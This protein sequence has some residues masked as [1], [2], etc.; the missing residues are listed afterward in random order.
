[1]TAYI[2][3]SGFMRSDEVRGALAVFPD[4]GRSLMVG[5][6]VSAKTLSGQRNKYPNRYPLVEDIAN[7]FTDD[8]RCLN[9]IHYAS[10]ERPTNAALEHLL[11]IGGPHC[12]GFQFNGE[13]PHRAGLV[14]LLLRAGPGLRVVLQVRDFDIPN[15]PYYG[16]LVTDVLIDA[17]GG[18]GL[19][20]NVTAARDGV[21]RF[22]NW[23]GLGCGVAGGLCAETVGALAPLMAECPGLSID[24]E[25]RLRTE[26][27]DLDMA[28]VRAYLRAS[29]DAIEAAASAR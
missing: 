17:S 20:L 10:D 28:K 5:V 27:D 15:K 25:G 3:V 12:H 19:P 13:W 6:L 18:R 11:R 29:A 1:M 8:P 16:G 26:E 23:D 7:I 22:L 9:L 24:A 2:G 14:G 21:R 4:C